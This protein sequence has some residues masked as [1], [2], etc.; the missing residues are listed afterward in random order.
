MAEENPSIPGCDLAIEKEI[1]IA[2]GPVL[3]DVELVQRPG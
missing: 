2:Q 3:A 1:A